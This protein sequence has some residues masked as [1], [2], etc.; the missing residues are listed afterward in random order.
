MRIIAG[1][2]RR[3]SLRAPAGHLTRPT[4][5][6]TRESLFHLV[7]SRLDLEGADVLDLFAGTGALGFE[8][9][10]RGGRA[11]TFVEHDGRVLRYTRQNAEDLDVL[12]SCTFLRADAVTYLQ[13]Y[14][15]PPFDLILADPPYTL[16]AIPRLPGLALPHLKPGG[17]FVL[18]HDRRHRFTDHPALDT[19]RP[20]GRT[21]VS[22]FRRVDEGADAPA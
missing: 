20:Y 22:V 19:S 1:R 7:E 8:A 16:P 13:R 12:E 6:R 11:V 2:L 15:G 4:T 21:T 14:D 9:L 5:D 17:L 10:S 18:E 3:R